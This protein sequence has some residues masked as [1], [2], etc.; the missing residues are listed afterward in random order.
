MRIGNPFQVQLILKEVERCS[1][2][3]EV[4]GDLVVEEAVKEELKKP[5]LYKVVMLN[6]DYTPMDFVVEV[7]RK[8]FGKDVAAATTIMLSVH[9]EGRAVCG[10]FTKDVAETKAAQVIQYARSHNHP[11]LCEVVVD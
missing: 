8:F 2:D 3:H 6:D 4:E 5:S 1:T 10:V 7:L 11:L 9:H